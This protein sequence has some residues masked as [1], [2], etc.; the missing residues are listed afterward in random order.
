MKIVKFVAEVDKSNCIG[1]KLCEAICPSG[2]I[3]VVAKKANVD[4]EKCLACTRCFD[5]CTQEAIT[6]VLRDQPK[7]V[8]TSSEGVDPT[9]I[10]ELCYKAHRRPDE[11]V[12][13]CTMTMAEEIAA[14][15]IKGARSVREVALMTGVLTGC[16]EFCV[17]VVQRMLKAYGVDIAKAGAPL[18]YDQTFSL[19]DIP[20]EVRQ[21]YPGYYFKEDRE[22]AT[23]LRK[24]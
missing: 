13:I 20:E 24:R 3:K 8:G 4:S 22:L 10:R 6:M 17:P 15:V 7:A 18:T 16:R 12:C 21:K 9:E 23:E 19:W 14:A 11:L 1:D 5:R 2:A